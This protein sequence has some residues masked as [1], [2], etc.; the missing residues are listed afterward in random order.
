MA[1]ISISIEVPDGL[2]QFID[3]LPLSVRQKHIKTLVDAYLKKNAKE[4]T[5]SV[6]KV[7]KA[8]TNESLNN[9]DK[10]LLEKES[11]D[12]CIKLGLPIP[13]DV[14]KT[15]AKPQKVK[16]ILKNEES[17]GDEVLEDIQRTVPSLGG[18]THSIEG[19]VVKKVVEVEVEAKEHL[20]VEGKGNQEIDLDSLPPEKQKAIND[21]NN[22]ENKG[23]THSR[24]T[25]EGQGVNMA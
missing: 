9:I 4:I 1:T 8:V 20:I 10:R 16:P 21:E 19:D 18:V 25:P 5:D 3:L 15:L 24:K 14:K 6:G 22:D 23:T 12:L 13:D 7:I 17:G 2:K 11:I